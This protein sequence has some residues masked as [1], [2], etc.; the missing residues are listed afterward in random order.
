MRTGVATLFLFSLALNAP[1]N[2]LVLDKTGLK[3]VVPFK[4]A[5]KKAQ[6]DARLLL[7][8][9]VAFGTSSDGGW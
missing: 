2:P 4:V 5:E 9:P 6:E 3:W 1:A 8:K 7:I